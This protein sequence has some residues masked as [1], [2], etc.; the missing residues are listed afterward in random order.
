LRLNKTMD[1]KQRQ[2]RDCFD[3]KWAKRD[4]YESAA[5]KKKSFRWLVDRYFGSVKELNDFL[6]RNKGKDI[7]DAG[8][9]SCFSASIL[10]GPALSQ[11]KYLGVDISDSIKVGHQ[12][13][14]EKGIEAEF[15]KSSLDCLK[16]DRRF[17]VVFCEGVLHH[18]SDPFLTLKNLVK[19]LKKNGQVMFYVYKKKAPVREFTDD[20]I[21]AQLA[22]VN[23]KEAWEKLIPLT[24]LGQTLGALNKK[25]TLKEDIDLLGIPRGT[26]DLQRLFYWYFLKMYYDRNFSVAEMNHI[27]F[28]WFRPLNCYRFTPDEVES[29]LKK[30]KLKKQRFVVEDAGITVVARKGDHE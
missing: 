19:H 9:G 11:M 15:L 1:K 6:K 26:Y 28:D 7:L 23:N 30:L 2:T 21:R 10:F 3:Y 14:A 27:N 20:L 8:C 13:L 29:W 5:L 25:I 4:T 24:K 16:L 22:K 17:D 12:R 18:T